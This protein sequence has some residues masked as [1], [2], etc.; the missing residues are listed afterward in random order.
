MLG[1]TIGIAG[2]IILAP[3]LL[4]LGLHPTVVAST[5]QYLAMISSFSVS[6]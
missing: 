6:G 1:G 4:E 2:G 3:L 5:N